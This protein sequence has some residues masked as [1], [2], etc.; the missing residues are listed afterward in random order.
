MH[1][2]A[3]DRKKMTGMNIRTGESGNDDGTLG[4]ETNAVGDEVWF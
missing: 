2:Y 4:I 1:Q 3:Y